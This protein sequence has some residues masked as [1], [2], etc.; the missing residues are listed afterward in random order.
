[1]YLIAEKNTKDIVPRQVSA[2]KLTFVKNWRSWLL[3]R[4]KNTEPGR[5][6]WPG[7]LALPGGA[8]TSGEGIASVQHGMP[9]MALN[10]ALLG[11]ARQVITNGSRHR[12]IA[13]RPVDRKCRQVS[14]RKA[15]RT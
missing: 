7:M 5:C 4:S 12:H 3:A 9:V 10:G 8:A 6:H 11:K 14:R 2:K 13:C 15:S 1:V